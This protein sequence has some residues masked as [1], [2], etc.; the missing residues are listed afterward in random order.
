MRSKYRAHPIFKVI[1]L[2]ICLAGL[3]TGNSWADEDSKYLNAVREFAD[4]VLKYGRDTYGPKHTPLFVDGLNIHT[5]E[6]VKWIAPNGDRWILSNLASQQNLFRTLDGLTKITGDPKYRQA[7][8]EAIEYA[9]ENL[10]SPNGLFYWGHVTAYDAKT[11]DICGWGKF[12]WGDIHTLKLHYPYYELMWKVNSEETKRSIE[13]FWSAH[14]L[15]WSNLDMDRLAYHKHALEEPWNHEYKR[16]P[17]FFKSKGS[18]SFGPIYTGTSLIHAGTTL[19]RLS[20]QEQPLVWSKRLAKRFIDT[21]H[22]N[23]GIS[24]EGYNR[25]YPQLGDDLKEHFADPRTIYFPWYAFQ[26]HVHYYYAEDSQAYSWISLLLAG[27]MLGEEGEEF[28]RWALE[29]FTAW[30]KASYRKKDNSFVPILTDGTSLEG[31][32]WKEAPSSGSEGHVI[33]PWPVGMQFFW[34]YGVAYHTTGDEF[35]W[36]MV[37]DIALGNNFGDIGQTPAHPTQLQTETTCSSV[38]GLL[39]FLELH[40]KT[41][42]QAYLEMARRI[43]DNILSSQFHKGFFIESKRH[44]YTRFDCFE[45][46]ALL[47]LDTAM[48]SKIGSVPRVWPSYPLFVPPYRYKENA[49]DRQIIYTLT[50]SPEPPLSLQEAAAIGDVNL[51]RTLIENGTDVDSI[52]DSY[53]K[54]ALHRAAMSGHRDVVEFL[55]TKGA[56][57]D[58][59]DYSVASPLHRAAEKGHK[60]VAELL[61]AKG[62]DVNA[63]N[64]D[65][66][67]PLHYAAASGRKD[68]AE[69]LIAKGADVNAKNDDDQTPVDVALSRIRSEVVK[70][71]IEKGADVSS[72]H[73]AAYLGDAAKVMNFIEQGS[74]VNTK[75]QRG[76]TP[77]HYAAAAGSKEV[78]E[79]LLA[80]GADIKAKNNDGQTPIDVAFQRKRED[81]VGLLLEKGATISTI[82]LAAYVGDLAKV[83]AFIQE[84]I[85]VNTK[86]IRGRMPLHYAARQGHKEIVELLLAHGAD[87]NLGDKYYNR[88]AA[89]FAMGRNHREIVELLVAK[90][91]DISPLCLA[92]YKGNWAKVKS[93]I[94]GGADVNIR[95]PYGVTPLYEAALQGHKSI[96]QLLID[97]GADVNA[98]DNWDWTPLHSAAEN[99]HRDVAELLIAKGADINA[100]DGDSRTPF[101]YAQD[102]GHTEIVELLRKHGAKE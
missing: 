60:E 77:L 46:L 34:A 73:L 78:S 28:S 47:H 20:G 67:T 63:K 64:N 88:T 30:G 4:N 75:H 11:D 43:G 85:D 44:I 76:G 45:P 41:K 1:L 97:N 61:I 17:T 69:L 26:T 91:A 96:V 5:H 90:G 65:G 56:D 37:R 35:M 18:N 101:W 62:A 80:R 82:H 83:K 38:Y 58:A 39:G 59:K 52:E 12:G 10:R 25:R 27:E 9:F 42:K 72:I 36:E 31:Y 84:D 33:K 68:I 71:L 92:A 13:A 86:Y 102:E 98:K 94:A 24:A 23:T 99:G 7:A 70:L 54:T 53:S 3:L 79:L 16:G 15:D 55:L 8:V 93:L 50:D 87:V 6:P 89:E 66:Q 40:A 14:I 57:I 49:V 51:V 95:T 19:Y 81:I 2:A 21:R 32:V 74:D 48:K 29:Q 100:R 22:P